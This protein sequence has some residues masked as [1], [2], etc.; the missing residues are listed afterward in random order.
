[1]ASVEEMHGVLAFSRVPHELSDELLDDA[2]ELWL[3]G[4]SPDAIAGDVAP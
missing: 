1:V 2:P 4:E 3:R